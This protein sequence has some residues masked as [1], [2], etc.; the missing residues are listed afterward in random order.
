MSG[1]FRTTMEAELEK[2][3]STLDRGTEVLIICWSGGAWTYDQQFTDV[4]DKWERFGKEYDEVALR[5]GAKLVAPKYVAVT[6]ESVKKIMKGI[7]AQV[8]R[9]GTTA[10]VP[11][12][13]LMMAAAPP[14][15]TVFFM[16]D[17]QIPSDKAKAT[18]DAIDAILK[19]S[20]QAPKVNSLWI[21]N[22]SFKPAPMKQLA[23]RF[24]GELNSIPVPKGVK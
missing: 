15:D 18:I 14:P 4:E 23:Q 11:P 12:F 1:A 10:W 5:K 3:L 24:D 13:T 8:Q 7:A 17:A 16:T 9:P 20:T 21:T 2:S 6:P 19:S 22:T